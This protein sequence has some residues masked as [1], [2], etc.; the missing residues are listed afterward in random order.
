[1]SSRPVGLHAGGAYFKK[2]INKNKRASSMVLL[3]LAG[4]ALQFSAIS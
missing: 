1:M 3:Y 4:L 2:S